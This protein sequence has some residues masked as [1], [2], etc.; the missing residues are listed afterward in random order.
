MKPRRGLHGKP[1]T[2]LL[3]AVLLGGASLAGEPAADEPIDARAFKV[4]HRALADAAQLVGSILSPDGSV[5]VQ[6]R[7][8]TLVVEDKVSVLDRVGGLLASFDLPPRNV[9][10]TLTLFLGTDRR[11][12]QAGRHAPRVGVSE[13]VRGVMETLG[14]FTKWT[15]YEPL[16][17][18]S[19]TGIE[20]GRVTTQLSEDY[21]VVFEIAS[22]QDAQQRITFRNFSLQRVIRTADGGVRY[23]DVYTADVS[24][25]TGGVH[26]VGA[27]SGPN[28]KKALFLTLQ[29]RPR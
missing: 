18:R 23:E 2:L 17:S 15:A 12:E 16:G 11:D 26:S 28:S 7:I 27:A 6:P 29:A 9:E 10:I 4:R 1:L 14:D 21:R 3:V 5:S 13:E 25:P 22:V 24:L 8:G 19:V 20:G